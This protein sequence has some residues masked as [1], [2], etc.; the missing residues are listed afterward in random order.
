VGGRGGEFEGRAQEVEGGVVEEGAGLAHVAGVVHVL[1]R[2]QEGDV[3]AQGAQAG[4]EALGEVGAA[5]GEASQ[6]VV[7]VG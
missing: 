2:G 3:E 1:A 4:V 7:G 6:G 5:P